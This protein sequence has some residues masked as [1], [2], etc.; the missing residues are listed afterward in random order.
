M[1]HKKAQKNPCTAKT[2]TYTRLSY[3]YLYATLWK[4]MQKKIMFIKI[5]PPNYMIKD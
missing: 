5:P 2:P 1:T 4:D 3:A